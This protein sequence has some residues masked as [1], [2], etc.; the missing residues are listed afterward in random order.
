LTGVPLPLGGVLGANR[1]SRVS[2][3]LVLVAVLLTLTILRAEGAMEQHF[4]YFPERALVMTP[5]GLGLPFEEVTFSAEDGIRLHGWWV[6]GEPGRPVILFFHG[7]AGNISHR[8]ENLWLLRRLGLGVLIF[9]YRGYGRSEGRP[10][11][12]G[13]AQDARAA[14][15]W[16]EERGV[17]RGELLYFGRS[18]GA[19]V[20]LQLA[21]E[22]PPAGL[23]LETPF[24]SIRDLG[25]LHYPLL[26]L[27]LGWLIR[28]RYDNLAKIGQ[29]HVPL[30]VLQ[31]DRDRIVPESMARRLYAAANPPKTFHLVVGADHNT[32]YEAGGDAY[33]QAWRDFLATLGRALS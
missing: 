20:A 24:T 30:L 9:D 1:R 25:R 13:L 21:L 26:H 7:N 4:I 5:S 16:L 19:A 28:D 32:T 6:P 17:P 12:P 31:G 10:D 15:K 3:V 8:V 2:R 18:L 22:A 23:V 27:G 33:W 29:L 11:E 14:L